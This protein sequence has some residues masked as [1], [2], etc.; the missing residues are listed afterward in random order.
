MFH[1]S[2]CIPYCSLRCSD[3]PPLAQTLPA[4][5]LV[6]KCR[7]SPESS[8]LNFNYLIFVSRTHLTIPNLWQQAVYINQILLLYNTAPSIAVYLYHSIHVYLHCIF[9]SVP[10][11]IDICNQFFN[12]QY[13]RMFAKR[14]PIQHLSS[15]T[16]S[17]R[18]TSSQIFQ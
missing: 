11:Q 13:R 12:Y 1:C 7:L 16:S 15:K 10:A 17:S 3:H 18:Q 5:M 6:S 9:I 2:L 14:V 4:L 8:R